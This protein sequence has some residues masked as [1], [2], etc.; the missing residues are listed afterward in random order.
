M[1][2]SSLGAILAL[3]LT[4][5]SF[6][7]NGVQSD[8][9]GD[10]S[11]DLATAVADLAGLDD[12]ATAMATPDLVPPPPKPPDLAL[13]PDM[14]L[15]TG[16][17]MGTIAATT[18]SPINLSVEGI[19]D[20]AHWGTAQANDFDHKNIATSLISDFTK[21]GGGGV[22]HLGT[23]SVGFSWNDGTPTA[24]ATNSTTGVYVSGN[25]SGFRITAP[26]DTTT[27]T[28]RLYCGGQMST[29]TVTAHLS[30]GSA[31]D[32]TTTSTAMAGDPMQW[33]RTITLLYRATS[34][35]TLTVSW[36]QST[37][38]GFVHLHSA[39]LQ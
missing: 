13:P 24:T 9:S 10:N 28:L 1:R 7:V 20:W 39:T 21:L 11:G 32:Y 35:A 36:T 4:G 27:R 34:T 8:A 22:T 37:N 16:L 31:A 14:A 26:A 23:Y 17:L 19:A 15:P 29:A 6:S 5:C 12:M 2:A 30:D 38:G 18:G 25:G 33:E 3:A